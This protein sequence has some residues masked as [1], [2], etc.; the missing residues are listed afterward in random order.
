MSKKPV[1]AVS[2]A[3]PVARKTGPPPYGKRS[4][5]VPRAQEDFGDGGAYPEI[6]VA[7]YPLDMGRK[8]KSTNR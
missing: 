2:A 8:G 1:P 5:F 3:A 7:Q 4:G 6:H